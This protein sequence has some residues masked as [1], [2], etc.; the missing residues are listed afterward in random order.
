[1]GRPNHPP[2]SHV[3]VGGAVAV[4]A[5]DTARQ[6]ALNCASVKVCQVLGDKPNFFCLLRLKRRC[7]SFF[8]TLSVWVDHFKSS[9]MCTPRNLKLSTCSTAVELR[10]HFV[11]ILTFCLFDCL[12]EGITTLFVFGHLASHLAIVKCGG[13]LI[14]FCMNATIY[15]R[16]LIRVGFNS[17]SRYNI[18]YTLPDKLSHRF[19]V[20]VDVILRGYTEHIPVCVV[21]TIL[22]RGF[23][24]VRPALKSP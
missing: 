16:F 18:S 22:K 13:S 4:P 19:R 15:P 1:M 5:G 20:L 12:M 8:T 7:C 21:K 6:D 3:V 14:Q 24:L 17:L 9:E 2:E 10:L 11:S 23:C